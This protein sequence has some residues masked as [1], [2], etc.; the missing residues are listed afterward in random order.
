MESDHRLRK[1]GFLINGVICLSPREAYEL[2]KSD[3]ILVDVRKAYE[4]NY[5]QFDVPDVIYLEEPR[6]EDDYSILPKQKK[7]IIADSVG[8]RSRKLSA[9]LLERGFADVSALAGGIIA[10]TDAMLPTKVD[11]SYQLS[12]QCACKL[13]TRSRKENDKKNGI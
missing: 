3:V 7:L 12:G 1:K 2:L 11:K 5:R 9:F 10:W 13:T 8:I 4:T 6:F